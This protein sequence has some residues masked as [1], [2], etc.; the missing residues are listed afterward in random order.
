MPRLDE[1]LALPLPHCLPF[2]RML[3]DPAV[4]V[5]LH[6]VHPLPMMTSSCLGGIESTLF[7]TPAVYFVHMYRLGFNG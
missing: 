6:C 4:T 1:L 5:R 7:H 2:R 3:T